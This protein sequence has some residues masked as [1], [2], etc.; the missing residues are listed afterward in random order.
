[1]SF[2][3]VSQ[4]APNFPDARVKNPLDGVAVAGGLALL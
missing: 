1:L 3:G 4:D 2:T